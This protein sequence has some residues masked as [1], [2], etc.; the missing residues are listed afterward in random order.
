MTSAERRRLSRP[1]RVTLAPALG[2][3][4]IDGAWWP[5]TVSVAHELPDLIFAVSERLGEIVDIAVNWSAIDGVID[6]DALTRR[7]AAPVIPGW[8]ARHQRVMTMTGA[9]ARA[10]LLVVPC[11]TSA[12]LAT[13]VMRRAAS[14]PILNRHMGTDAYR[15]ADDIVRAAG[16]EC[17]ERARQ[18]GDAQMYEAPTPLPTNQS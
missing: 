4:S 10:N 11:G 3:D 14:L 7:G 8:S 9:K 16:A 18:G 5:H 6:L 2:E 15:V 17:A 13:M 1:T 12:G